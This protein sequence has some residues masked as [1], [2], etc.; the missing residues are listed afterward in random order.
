A[1]KVKLS[2]LDT[3]LNLAYARLN[4][5]N[6]FTGDLNISGTKNVT[7]DGGKVNTFDL[8]VSGT[9]NVQ[10]LV[11]S[12][13]NS[14][15][16]VTGQTNTTDLNVQNNLVVKGVLGGNTSGVILVN[17][18]NALTLEGGRINAVDLNISD[19]IFA[20]NSA[21]SAVTL[22]DD[23]NAAGTISGL[24]LNAFRS[25]LIG[26]GASV[27]PVTLT[28]NQLVSNSGAV[29]L[30]DD[31]NVAGT[32]S[33]W[34][35][36]ASRDLNALGN[37]YVTGAASKILFGNATNA[38]MVNA[39]DINT[40]GTLYM[41]GNFGRIIMGNPTTTAGPA[42]L[43]TTG[44]IVTGWDLNILNDVAQGAADDNRQLWIDGNI[45]IKTKAGSWLTCNVVGAAVG[46]GVV[47]P[48]IT[49][50]GI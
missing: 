5:N 23:F 46:V 4:A 15:F 50:T 2:S 11:L 22:S 44:S 24:D 18:T 42:D 47:A 36:N 29:T 37:L 6:V 40:S 25:I 20:V 14:T 27:G 39:G 45:Q 8:N 7:L 34:D 49:C 31:L 35:L 21:L 38:T 16:T 28:Y 30:N 32:I 9:L 17:D 3:D 43:V 26:T 10:S 12:S 1:G 41:Y 48:N 33:A 19:K 13:G